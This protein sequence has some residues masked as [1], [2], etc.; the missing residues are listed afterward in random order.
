M[1]DGVSSRGIEGA[2]VTGVSACVIVSGIGGGQA[3]VSGW[4]GSVNPC[5]WWL[6][7][8][9]VGEVHVSPGHTGGAFVTAADIIGSATGGDILGGRAAVSGWVG[10][11]T[12][13]GWWFDRWLIGGLPVAGSGQRVLEPMP[14]PDVALTFSSR[15]RGLES[16]MASSRGLLAARSF[17][18]TWDASQLSE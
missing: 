14:L 4:V 17:R 15:A 2:F 11:L 8:W 16:S 9:L 18:I 6:R 13:C 3:T 1:I 7:R 5:D 12:S 10:S